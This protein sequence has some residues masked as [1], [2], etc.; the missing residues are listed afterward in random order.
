MTNRLTINE[1]AMGLAWMASQR[2]ED[3]YG[4]VGAA[5]LTADNR[6]IATGYNGLAGQF[7]PP[8]GFW[9]DRDKRRPYMLHAEA[10]L[11]A[12]TER[13]QVA[14]VA[15]TLLPCSDCARNIITHGIKRVLYSEEYAYDAIAHDIFKFYGV[16]LTR[17]PV[18]GVLAKIGA[19]LQTQ[20]V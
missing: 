7:T 13:G 14:L 3:P 6:V 16:E 20:P 19:V 18:A 1:Y 12:L 8:P 17:V 9:D 15:C 10:N 4:K 5:A 11:L 2:S